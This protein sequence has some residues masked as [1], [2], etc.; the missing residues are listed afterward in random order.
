MEGSNG[1]LAGVLYC[2]TGREKTMDRYAVKEII[3]SHK[4]R[5]YK[6]PIGVLAGNVE[7]DD[8][9]QFVSKKEKE[10]IT[11]PESISI[12]FNDKG[13]DRTDLKSGSTLEKLFGQIASWVSVIKGLGDA[14]ECDATQELN[15]TRDGYVADARALKTVNDKFGGISF[16]K[17]GGDIYAV[18]GTGADAVLKKLGENSVEIIDLTDVPYSDNSSHDSR[19]HIAE[20]SYTCTRDGNCTVMYSVYGWQHSDAGNIGAVVGFRIDR[21]GEEVASWEGK[22]TGKYDSAGKLDS[23][24]VPVAEGDVIRSVAYYNSVT[25]AIKIWTAVY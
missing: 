9:R 20:K 17:E 8:E 19:G 13:N 14:A 10:K 2:K 6:F 18:Y 4:G 11:K 23:V 5:K 7:T 25:P 1:T 15:V 22:P 16:R 21:N 12:D 24:T 3:K